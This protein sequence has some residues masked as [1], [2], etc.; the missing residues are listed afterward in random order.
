MEPVLKSKKLDNVIVYSL[1]NYNKFG[2]EKYCGITDCP[3]ARM[4]NHNSNG[5][6]TQGWIILGEF[7]TREEALIAE[8][9]YHENGYGGKYGFEKQV[10]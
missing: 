5:N 9:S 2:Y 6:N 3:S 7:E 10:A 1:P 8:A 4:A